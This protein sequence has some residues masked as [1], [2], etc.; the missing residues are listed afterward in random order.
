M[1]HY[2]EKS[3]KNNADKINK[4]ILGL[5][6]VSVVGI[7]YNQYV[8]SGFMPNTAV[9]FISFSLIFLLVGFTAW[10]LVKEDGSS[11]TES[12]TNISEKPPWSINEK[13]SAALVVAITA[14]I[15]FNQVQISNSKEMITGRTSGS[16]FF[17]SLSPIKLGSGKGGMIIGPKIN[18]DGRTTRLVEFKTISETPPPKDTGNSVQDAIA[19][20]VPKGIPFYVTS[21]PGSEKIQ[22]ASFDDPMTSQKV[23]ASLLGSKRFGSSNE[24]KLTPEEQKRWEGIVSVFTC[25]Y[26]CGSPKSVT[27]INRCGCA[28]SYGWQGMAKFFIKYYPNYTDDEIKGEMTK[29]KAIW[30]PQGMIQNYLVYTGQQ[31]ASILTTQGG[32][33]GIKQQFLEQGA[34]GSKATESSVEPLENLPSMVGGC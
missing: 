29:W 8:F 17:S 22:G 26:C 12:R 6:L 30:Y 7:V 19:T 32:S 34:S 13:I 21:G 11:K 9:N 18:S 5:L 23:W 1:V 25:D 28:H 20:V 24:I 4:I 27:T 3:N 15:L 2:S 10:L 31:P 33:I 16:G 14:I